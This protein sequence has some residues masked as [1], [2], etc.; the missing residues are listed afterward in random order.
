MQIDVPCDRRCGVGVRDMVLQVVLRQ[1]MVADDTVAF[2]LAARRGNPR[3]GDPS[4]IRPFR[5]VVLQPVPV[6]EDGEEAVVANAF[7]VL[8]HVAQEAGLLFP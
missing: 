5:R 7:G 6:R 4:V 1:D 3:E 8:R 2:A